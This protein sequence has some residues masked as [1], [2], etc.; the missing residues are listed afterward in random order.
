MAQIL[1][2]VLAV[3]AGLPI[4]LFCIT[5]V[6]LFIAPREV[7][8]ANGFAFIFCLPSAFFGVQAGLEDARNTPLQ[9]NDSFYQLVIY[10]F[11]TLVVALILYTS[12]RGRLSGGWWLDALALVVTV[13]STNYFLE[14]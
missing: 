1:Q 8:I 12:V 9:T 13:V 4:F 14:M 10:G 2:L 7:W 3:L 11:S 5:L 6:R